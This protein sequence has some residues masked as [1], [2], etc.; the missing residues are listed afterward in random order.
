MDMQIVFART[1]KGREEL[2]GAGRTLKPRHRQ[3][4]FL[5]SDA[6]SVAD[7]KAKLP[8]CQEL[9]NI[10]EQLWD[11]GFIGQVK[12]HGAKAAAVSEAPPQPDIGAALKVLSGSR[13]EAARQYA[14]NVLA[15]LVGEQ[16]PV[17][18]RLQSAQGHD[19]F[20]EAI[21]QSKKL[22]AAVAS[23]SQAAEFERGVMAILNLP[24]S[25]Q[26]PA[27]PVNPGMLNGIEHAKGHALEIIASLVGERSPVYAKVNNTH[28]RAEFIEAIG[29]SRKVIAA[30]ASAS[31]A[32]DFEK[33]VLALMQKH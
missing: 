19:A 16:S 22:L 31:H 23:A 11:E 32:Q 1:E 20:V 28:N 17:H 24:E 15:G 27:A 18:A 21:A 33:E 2:L 4:L 5:V 30:V 9:E 26:A 29:A 8:S 12:Q 14:L 13:L 3:V 6:I 10:L 7:L 25:D